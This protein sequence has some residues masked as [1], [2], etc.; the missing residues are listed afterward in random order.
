M[1]KRVIYSYEEVRL[2]HIYISLEWNMYLV[3]EYH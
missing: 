2:L 3:N 1:K